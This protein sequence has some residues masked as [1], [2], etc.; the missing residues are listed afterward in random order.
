MESAIGAAINM[1]SMPKNIGKMQINGTKQMISRIKDVKT[2]K[3]GFPTAWKKMED[4]L[5]TQ[6]NVTR[7]RK[8]RNVFLAKSQ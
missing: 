1:P 4:I 7:D 2:A 8:I 3:T 5:M 6:V